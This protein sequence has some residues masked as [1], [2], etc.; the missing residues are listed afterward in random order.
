MK[1]SF[2]Y[3]LVIFKVYVKL[4]EVPSDNLLHS[5]WK[6]QSNSLSYLLDMVGDFPV[7]Y[8]SLPEANP[9][10]IPIRSLYWIILIAI[11]CYTSIK[12]HLPSGY[13]TVRHG[14]IHPFYHF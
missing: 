12:I 14:K 13:L 5:Y 1:M 9:I 2:H 7:R 6:L 10:D 3:K 8:V 11:G 4:P